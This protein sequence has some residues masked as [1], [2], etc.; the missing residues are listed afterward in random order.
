MKVALFYPPVG[1]TGQPYLSTA[2]LTAYLK[3]HGVSD[4]SQHDFNLTTIEAL[5]S[6]ERLQRAYRWCCHYLQK[7]SQRT[8]FSDIEAMQ[9]QLSLQTMV[10]GPQVVRDIEKA[11]EVFRTEGFFDQKK[12][13]HALDTVRAAY[14]VLSS[15]YFPTMINNQSLTMGYRLDVSDDILQ[16]VE[17]E[18]ANCFV[19]IFTDELQTVFES[20]GT[21][22]IA[23]I[24]I[25]YYEQLVPGFTLARLIKKY[26]PDTHVTVGGTMMSALFQKK[27]P[28][29]FFR[30]FDSV[31]FFEA[32]ISLLQLVQT[33]ADNK[34]IA[35]VSNLA[36]CRN[37]QVIRTPV[38]SER[39]PAD[40]LP[41]P[42]FDG[43]PLSRYLSPEA[44]LPLA[45]SRGCYWRKCTFCT[46]QHF[47]DCF[48]QRSPEKIINDMITLKNR[49]GA[50]NFFFV[51]ECVSPAVLNALAEGIVAA[52]LNIRWS[53]YVRF[54]KKLADKTFCRKLARSG[55]RMLY[56]GLESACQRIIDLMGK[57][58][59]KET[60]ARVISAT[61]SA[62]ILNM[63]LYF[64]G[65][66]SETREEAMETMTFLMDNQKHVTFALAGQFLLEE[67]SQIFAD[68]ERFGITEISPL[69][70]RSDLGIIYNYK[71]ASGL[72]SIEATE[73]KESINRQTEI[74]HCLDFL[75]RA[76]LLFHK[77]P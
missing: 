67:N 65:F 68:P 11:K 10:Q 76:H 29:E 49:Y 55:L 52:G 77:K 20:E 45:G 22:G 27:F 58:V 50:K 69:S 61:G 9:L 17:D 14:Q 35:K 71:T 72:S 6:P 46:R 44:V 43:L 42:D 48:R 13:Q 7:S 59:R 24:S 63:I 64:V 3:Q 41:T 18:E 57:G 34:D 47:I 23:G 5:L 36:Y 25:G 16:A 60:I 51:D 33:L 62:G 70:S 38:S 12:Y 8:G 26:W 31:L 37:G 75:N 32:E 39:V 4:V 1:N 53:C 2:A 21:P 54:E 30:W 28:L 73:I 74:L 19:E 15:R 56:F 66:P 40:A